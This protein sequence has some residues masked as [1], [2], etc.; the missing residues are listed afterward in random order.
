MHKAF[1]FL[2]KSSG[3]FSFEALSVAKEANND[4]FSTVHPIMVLDGFQCEHSIEIRLG[5]RMNLRPF[6]L[7][8]FS[9]FLD[10][11]GHNLDHYESSSTALNRTEVDLDIR[12]KILVIELVFEP[13]FNVALRS[14]LFEGEMEDVHVLGDL[15]VILSAY[16]PEGVFGY[17]DSEPGEMG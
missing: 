4:F 7:D 15:C 3:V 16:L 5:P 11:S 9:D 2:L 8:L 13:V 1:E 12:N 6:L 10:R 14:I 17:F